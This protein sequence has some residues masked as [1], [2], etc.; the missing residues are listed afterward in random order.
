[1]IP[2]P[3]E[4]LRR[5]ALVADGE[6]GAVTGPHGEI[7]FL[8]A[9][10]WHDDA[11][12]SSL[13]GG[14]GGYVVAPVG[15]LAVHGGSYLPGTLV[16]TDR[17]VTADGVVECQQALAMPADPHRVVLLRRIRSVDAGVRVA[18]TL[19]CRAGFGAEPMVL[20][21]R[22]AESWEA[23]TGGLHLRWS[24]A[25]DARPDGGALRL[26]LGLRP[27]EEHD[28]VLEI[29]D[30]PLDAP[31]PDPEPAW[32][33]TLQVWRD[34]VPALTDSVAPAESRH[35]YAVLRG[36]TAGTGAMVAAAT[37][38][39][40]EQVEQGRNYDYRFAWVRD[41]CLVGQAL[42]AVGGNPLLDGA[43][44]VVADR[45]LREQLCEIF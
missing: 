39:L 13:L 16:W 6:R 9:P 26:E 27:G 19:E 21:G 23:T 33:R 14:E 17:W 34:E 45:L 38:S 28:L 35:S 18:A 1:M 2:C 4:P 44:R 25:A 8:C 32:E 37:T 40:P 5:Y 11:V 41:Q 3:P 30:H 7:A 36:L 10:R 12:F 15:A 29:A 24:G 42:A 31:P 22:V 43:V 20:S